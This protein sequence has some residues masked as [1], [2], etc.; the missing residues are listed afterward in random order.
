[1][2]CLL[3]PDLCDEIRRKIQGKVGLIPTVPQNDS[4]V[5][6]NSSDNP[7]QVGISWTPPTSKLFTEEK[8]GDPTS[9]V[10]TALLLFLIIAYLAYFLGMK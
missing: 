9:H 1:M 7:D 2:N 5:P 4:M 3:R 8:D 10:V 6:D